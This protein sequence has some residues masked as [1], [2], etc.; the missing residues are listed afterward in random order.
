MYGS[1]LFTW[2]IIFDFFLFKKFLYLQ[3]VLHPSWLQK[4]E[5]S[6]SQ[7]VY[8][9]GQSITISCIS[10]NN[11]MENSTATCSEVTFIF[12][13]INFLCIPSES[14]IFE[15][16]LFFHMSRAR[17]AMWLDVENG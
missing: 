17:T 14:S 8:S 10:E 3:L 6:P 16:L 13:D 1:S 5:L 9:P 12:E 2:Q 11:F 15:I 4:A 7:E